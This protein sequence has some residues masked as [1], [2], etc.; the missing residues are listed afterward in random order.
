MHRQ[1]AHHAAKPNMQEHVRRQATS[2]GV[3]VGL[4]WLTWTKQ[5]TKGVMRSIDFLVVYSRGSHAFVHDLKVEEAC[6]RDLMGRG[7]SEF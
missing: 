6:G 2:M 3:C 4:W 5:S 7:Y 1:V